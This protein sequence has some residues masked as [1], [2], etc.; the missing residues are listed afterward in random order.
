MLLR[1][2]EQMSNL[3]KKILA[4]IS[5][6]LFFSMFYIR[7]F[8]L[9]ISES[10]IPPFFVSD[11]SES[12]RLLTKNERIAQVTHQKWETMSD[13]LTLLR[14]NERWWANR[15]GHSLKMSKWVNHWFFWANRSFAHFGQKT[16]DLLRKSMIEFPALLIFSERPEQFAHIAHFWWVSFAF[17]SYR[18][19]KKM[20]W[21][22]PLF[23]FTYIKHTVAA[24]NPP[25]E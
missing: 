18:S 21:A 14:G 16:S 17:R 24:R 8:I 4:K 19:P 11:V 1:E 7:F 20:E 5:K 9:K 25:V 2:N 12:L 6:I 3:L 23:F 10:L 22:N 15:S 13:L